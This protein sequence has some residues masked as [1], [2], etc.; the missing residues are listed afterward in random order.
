MSAFQFTRGERVALL[1]RLLPQ[2][3]AMRLEVLPAR[4]DQEPK[5]MPDKPNFV[6]AAHALDVVR[7]LEY[8]VGKDLEYQEKRKA[9]AAA[10]RATGQVPAEDNRVPYDEQPWGSTS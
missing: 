9:H 2:F 4:G 3:V 5:A 10:Q 7:A 6:A 8:Q 1:S